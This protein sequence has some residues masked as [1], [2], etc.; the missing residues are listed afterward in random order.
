MVEKLGQVAVF[1]LFSL[2]A[3][4]VLTKL[5]GKRQMSQ[6]TM[7]DYVIGISFGSLASEMAAHPDQES[8]YVLEAMGIYALVTV[9]IN[10]INLHSLKSRKLFLGAPLV[11]FDRGRLYL[12]SLKKAKIDLNEL[13]AECRTAGYFDLEELEM[14]LLEVNGKLS[15]LPKSE[16]RPLT[17][18]DMH[19]NPGLERP[20]VAV[21][22]DGVVFPERLHA[23]G[24]EKK[25]LD[26]QLRSLGYTD[27]RKVLLACVNEG[28]LTVY[29][30]EAEKPK[31]CYN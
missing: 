20:S 29:P 21:V 23:I 11:I 24:F 15:F 14:I 25:W 6:M 10:V 9:L 18:Q 1:S 17:P 28:R 22:M 7:F 26:R 30:R 5:M 8:W 31:D 27:Y 2:V 19:V 4:F 16:R 12:S 13:L 3:L